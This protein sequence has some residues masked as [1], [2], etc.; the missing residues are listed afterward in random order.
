MLIGTFLDLF[1]NELRNAR[2]QNLGSAPSSPVIGQIY[3]NTASSANTSMQVYMYVSSVAQWVTL[4]TSASS[5]TGGGMINQIAY[6]SSTNNL[7]G[8]ST[9]ASSVLVTNV[10]G[11]PGLST[12]LPT[13]VTIGSAYI[14]RVGG[15]KVAVTDGG[16]GAG[17]WTQYGIFYASAVSTF[18]QITDI[19]VTGKALVSTNSGAPVFG[20]VTLTQP[21]SQATL[22]LY[23]GSTLATTGGA[24]TTTLN[25]TAASTVTMPASTSA[26]MNYYVTAPAQYALP[27]AGS[28][29]GLI[30][31]LAVP[32]V[33]S[34]LTGNTTTAPAWVTATGTGAPVLGTSPTI[35][36]PTITGGATF[37]TGTSSVSS[38][39]TLNIPSGASLTIASGA[40]FTSANTPVNPT[41]VTNKQYVD[42]AVQGL[43]QKPT[44][45]LATNTSLPG[46]V[47]NNGTAGVGATLTA[48]SYGALSVDSIPVQ[49]NDVILV[50]NESSQANNGLYTVTATGGV[51]AYYVL[52]RHVEMDIAADFAG[53]FIPVANSA[54]V[55]TAGSQTVA[56][57]SVAKTVIL[58]GSGT[59]NWVL[60]GVSAGEAIELA[61]FTSLTGNNGV[62]TVSTITTT[63]STNDTI[64]YTIGPAL[65]TT[66]SQV[67]GISAYL[68]GVANSNT[69]WL[70]EDYGTIT[71][72][73]TA[74]TFAQ[75]NS[76][77]ALSAGTGITI[78][79]NTISLSNQVTAGGPV[80][81]ATVV[82]II[83]Y[84]AQG[85]LTTVSSTTISGVSPAGA[86]LTTG[87]IWYGVAGIATAV[88]ISGVIAISSS[89]VTSFSSTTGSGAT[90]LANT[91]TLITPNL[92]AATATSINGL[93]I[94][95]STGTLT[96]ANGA[97]INHSGAYVT[98][99]TSTAAT[100]V[101]LPTSGTLLSTTNTLGYAL[102]ALPTDSVQS[103]SWNA[104][105]TSWQFE[106][107]IPYHGVWY[108]T[109]NLVYETTLTY[110][111]T[112][113]AR[114]LTI[115]PTS[116]TYRI[117]I[118]G[119]EYIF[120]GGQTIQHAATQG[121]W[122]IYY[123]GSG[124]LTASQ[125]VWNLLAV[126]P[127]AIVYYDAT[128]PD[129]WLFDERHHH[130]TPAEWH[131][132]QHFAIGTF[133]KT[134]ATDFVLGSYTIGT[135]SNAGQ[136]WS[137]STGT[138]VDEDINILCSAIAA[139]GPYQLFAKIGTS[140]NFIRTS[141]T[142]PFYY[143][144]STLN[145]QYNQ[146]TGTTWQLTDVSG[147]GPGNYTNYY[148]FATTGY[149]SATPKQIMII[150]SQN[151]FTS[152]AS[153]QAEDVSNLNLTQFPSI[154]FAPV[155]QVSF[156][157][158]APANTNDGRSDIAAITRIVASKSTV[159]LAAPTFTNPMTTLGDM[160]WG[161]VSGAPSRVAGST[162]ATI[163]VLSQTGTGSA[164]A[165][166]SWI[167]STGTGT[168]VLA[169]SPSLVTPSLGAATATSINGLTISVTTGTLNIASS[170]TLALTGAFTTTLS[171]SA[172][173][174]VTLPGASGT[175]VYYTSGNAPTV[176]YQ[177]PY[178][179]AGSGSVA[180][181]AVN[182]TATNYYLR[183]VSSGAPVFAAINTADITNAL[184]F[185][186]TKKYT[187]TITGPGPTYT[188]T[189]NLGTQYIVVVVMDASYNVQIPDVQA[190]STNTATLTYGLG[191]P[192]ASTYF[193]T[194]VG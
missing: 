18:G 82:P 49:V 166:P 97:T 96:I 192:G 180:Y 128:T 55:I 172:T 10:S 151:T 112:S 95:S 63:T 11:V 98:T 105:T 171:A 17:T 187:T 32:S 92:G 28:A 48:S 174:T 50:K 64:T 133:V 81:S 141:S 8:I 13:A 188:I 144:G 150:P 158:H 113:P 152:L 176:A 34:V 110:T 184:G 126:V 138:A 185:T 116:S 52:T 41:D 54:S 108:D 177:V 175:L 169:T 65:L 90:V 134:P 170:A 139:G 99:I 87:D 121:L 91:P 114:T 46:N 29:S 37:S 168:N 43:T 104:N 89:G 58:S 74:I 23:S 68:T 38:G 86:A 130:D 75:L 162:S 16:T 35:G 3:T 186:P 165:Q 140:G 157:C 7:A 164:S 189:H 102:P 115:N 72:G 109:T 27:Y 148:I 84:N 5:I 83:T 118:L 194:V 36:T 117:W 31:Y 123:N 160:I 156:L 161:D 181:T 33:L 106:G 131:Q 132:S 153:A 59:L 124:V 100:S 142:L 53:A 122:Y 21:G 149:D 60:L 12:D 1:Q 71:V 42:S 136:Q 44:A 2:I 45:R 94:S 193:V 67:G 25:A 73:T 20:T 147:A 107:E 14:Y 163:A 30:T 76:A 66:G 9:A 24:F 88:N 145:I 167:L 137:L 178:T 78:S 56:I 143:N 125:T 111:L 69:L 39:A 191:A 182:S 70:C 22:T 101:T 103:L 127:V 47:Y 173:A 26:T 135:A 77:T 80:G 19:S 61:G 119:T 154:E 93:T 146:Y 79:G 51:S 57:N 120:T 183:Q 4:S 159:A 85:Q 15:T 62:Y 129:F 40:T 6:F 179:T 155:Y 190:T